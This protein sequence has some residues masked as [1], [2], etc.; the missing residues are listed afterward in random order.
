MM[1]ESSIYK[2][3]PEIKNSFIDKKLI[4]KSLKRVICDFGSIENFNNTLWENYEKRRVNLY[5]REINILASS[6]LIE[7]PIE[8]I[9][10]VT[11]LSVFMMKQ[12]KEI[13]D[14]FYKAMELNKKYYNYD[15]MRIR[16]ILTEYVRINLFF[17][18]DKRE[19]SEEFGIYIEFLYKAKSLNK[20]NIASLFEKFMNELKIVD[21]KYEKIEKKSIKNKSEE[22]ASYFERYIKEYSE[23]KA[24]KTCMTIKSHLKNF[25]DFLYKYYPKIN[26]FNML[27]NKHIKEFCRVREEI[28]GVSNATINHGLDALKNFLYY[29]DNNSKLKLSVSDIITSY[30][31]FKEYTTSVVYI[32][33]VDSKRL[34]KAIEKIDSKYRQEK[35]ILYML[36][37]TGRRFHEI[38]LLGYDCIDLDFLY[39][40]K[41]KKGKK[42]KVKIDDLTIKFIKEAQRIVSQFD[43]PLFS[44]KDG[45]NKRRLFASE[46]NYFKNIVSDGSVKKVLKRAQIENGI[47]NSKGEVLFT[48]HDLKR[49]AISNLESCGINIHDIAKLLDQSIETIC[50]YESRNDLA[51]KTLKRVE[52]K[53]SLIGESDDEKLDG[54]KEYIRE[55]IESVDILKRNEYNLQAKLQEP[56]NMIPLFLGSC[57]DIESIDACGSL[58]CATCKNFVFTCEDDVMKFEVFCQ[59]FYRQQIRLRKVRKVSD[60]YKEAE[61]NIKKVMKEKLNMSDLEI[62]K[63]INKIKK[64]VKNEEMDKNDRTKKTTS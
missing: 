47:I 29:V 39:I 61:Q 38:Q 23:S 9:F 58:F 56:E 7:I 43:K 4:D 60:M 6:G 30:D 48:V 45:M 36:F 24:N 18:F 19:L 3:K 44:P 21:Y 53:G 27:E 52:E 57:T 46:K 10:D 55:L 33:K 28:D 54:K 31:K 16:C 34:I 13:E 15:V 11:I 22:F 8:Y 62:K 51:F 37:I 50:R 35:L 32:S 5:T 26:Q 1:R 42:H 17:G 20:K 14:F 40:E 49:I 41:T 64:E 12:C 25:F 2:L 63:K 59:K